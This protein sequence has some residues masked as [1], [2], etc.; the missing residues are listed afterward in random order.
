[1]ALAVVGWMHV[2]I[3]EETMQGKATSPED[4]YI[5]LFSREKHELPQVGLAIHTRQTVPSVRTLLFRWYDRAVPGG[6][7]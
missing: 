7:R 1:M 5:V 6:P 4:S 2:N 3:S